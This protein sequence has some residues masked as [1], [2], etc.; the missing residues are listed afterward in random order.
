MTADTD[1]Q[2]AGSSWLPAILGIGE[3]YVGCTSLARLNLDG[4]MDLDF[5]PLLAKADGTLPD[6]YMIKIPGMAA[7][8]SWWGVILPPSTGWPAAASCA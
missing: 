3:G 1:W 8:I 2:V 4:S 7:G 6:I 5:K